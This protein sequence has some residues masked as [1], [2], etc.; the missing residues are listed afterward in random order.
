M[1]AF[2]VLQVTAREAVIELEE[3]AIYRTQP[4][5]ILLDGE[6]VKESDRMVTSIFGL[7]PDSDVTISLKRGDEESSCTIHTAQETACLNPR[8][9][10]AFGDGEHDDTN[11]LQAAILCCPDGGRVAVEEGTYPVTGLF[12]KSKITL[13]LKKGACIA[14]IY[15]RDRI[16]I[17]PAEI[18]WKE[19]GSARHLGTW[20]GVPAPMFV[21]LLT[22]VRVNNVTICGEGTIDGRA[23][24]DNWWKDHKTLYRAWRPRMIFLNH[25]K[26]VSVFGITVKDSPA[27]NLHPYFSQNLRF[28]DL[29]IKG[30]WNSH[31][32]DGCDPESCSNVEIVGV[33]FSVGDDCIA[34][35]SG[36]I[37]MGRTYKQPSEHIE[38]RQCYMHDGHGAFT[39]GSEIGAG[40]D[41]IRMISCLFE[42]TD[43]GLRIKTRRGRGKDS[44]L[45]GILCEN[46]KM[47]GVKAPFVVNSFYY[48]D[49]DGKTDYVQCRQP[50]PVDDRT[51]YV[52]DLT[53]RNI[54]CENAHFCAAHVSG[55]P[56]QKIDR[57]TL[58][59]VRVSYAE[60]AQAGEAAMACGVDATRKAGLIVSN[61]K[62]LVLKDVAIAGA[63][64]EV[65]TMENV[66]TVSG[67]IQEV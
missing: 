16:P 34:V 4:Y 39:V 38:V 7:E 11:A 61:V 23:S 13:E 25:C 9:F 29:F 33:H 19:G 14:G 48:C 55:L 56:E 31:N 37:D 32:T 52:R 63:E 12:L 50:L 51:P 21:S 60:N 65:L 46:L 22:G 24:F 3:Q 10:G 62:E 36:K 40:V 64:G 1:P 45:K 47:D 44:V 26:D 58:E 42:N 53:F 18:D 27:W 17:L 20:E 66:E 43:R 8:S 30:P 2:H 35:K 49:A 5:Q 67:E 57:L 41:D 59:N 15:D 28:M 54:D 6:P